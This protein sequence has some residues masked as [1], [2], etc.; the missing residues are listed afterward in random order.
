MKDLKFKNLRHPKSTI[1][2]IIN[3]LDKKASRTFY[4]L[5]ISLI[6]RV[7]KSADA[8]CF[9]RCLVC[10]LDTAYVMTSFTHQPWTNVSSWDLK[11]E[12]WHDGRL[13]KSLG[14][15][16]SNSARVSMQFFLVTFV[17]CYTKPEFKLRSINKKWGDE[18]IGNGNTIDRL[19][20]IISQNNLKIFWLMQ[21]TPGLLALHAMKNVIAFLN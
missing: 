9:F 13:C 17:K 11:G 14:L 20:L 18:K 19:C 4:T 5:V 6:R 12:G 15:K 7:K 10:G 3:S 8:T 1:K 16:S 21:H 2:G